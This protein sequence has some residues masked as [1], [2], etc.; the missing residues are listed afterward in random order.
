MSDS[1]QLNGGMVVIR[2]MQAEDLDQVQAID[3]ISFSMP[4][5]ES[6]YR[7]ELFDNLGSLLWVAEY[8]DAAGASRVVGMVVIWLVLDEVHIATIA[9]HPDY[10]GQG[11]AQQ[12]LCTAL[13]ASIEK[14]MTSATLEVRAHNLAAQ[15][16]YRGFRFEETGVRPRYYRD[17]FEDALIMTASKLDQDYLS[18]LKTGAWRK[19]D[20]PSGCADARLAAAHRVRMQEID[21]ETRG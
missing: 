10:R 18:W 6:A 12:L 17:N 4:W 14:G 21:H 5:P 8:Q 1:L 2:P 13:I 11:I 19:G 3:K 20:E 15:R 9:V 16:L 7:Y